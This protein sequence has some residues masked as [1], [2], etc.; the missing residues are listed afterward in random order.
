MN[1]NQKL[2]ENQTNLEASNVR[3][4]LNSLY[5]G[6]RLHTLETQQFRDVTVPAAIKGWAEIARLKDHEYFAIP[7]GS[8]R[9]LP[10]ELSD[11]D[12]ILVLNTDHEPLENYYSDYSLIDSL[13]LEGNIN[14]KKVE[15]VD[16]FKSSKFQADRKLW[17][18][19]IDKGFEAPI[20]VNLIAELMLTP[21]SLIVGNVQLARKMRK[22]AIEFIDEAGDVNA[23]WDAEDSAMNKRARSIFSQWSERSDYIGEKSQT[24]SRRTRF[25]QAIE[26]IVL[27]INNRYG[28]RSDVLASPGQKWE[29]AFKKSLRNL[30]MPNFQTYKK[31]LYFTGGSLDI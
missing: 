24:N 26:K 17:M 8:A 29:E 19:N 13:P 31:A 1:E 6:H 11:V 27:A 18:A 10:N 22:M 4:F 23:L 3:R 5:V 28:V 25:N 21:D 30:A 14:G 2:T 9:T 12:F 15:I 16:V 7:V 20:N